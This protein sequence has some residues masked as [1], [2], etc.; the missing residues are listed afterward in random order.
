MI[1]HDDFYARACECEY[2]KPILDSDDNNLVTLKPPKNPI[3]FEEAADEMRSTP[4]TIRGN[5]PEIFP[6]TDRLCD[7]TDTDHYMQPDADTSVEQPHPT[8][9]NARSSKFDLRHIPKPICDEDYSY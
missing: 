7:G 1:K 2:D 9:T 8:P 3:Q 5:C 6:Q 4:G